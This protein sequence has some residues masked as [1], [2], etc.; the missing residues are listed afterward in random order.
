[1]KTVWS[2]VLTFGAMLIVLSGCGGGSTPPPPTTPPTITTTTVPGG[3]VNT[4]YSTTLSA[5]GGTAP[6]SWSVSSGTLPAGIKLSTSGTLSGTPTAAGKSSF[7]VQVTD[8]ANLSATQPLTLE[9][10]SGTLAFTNAAP[11]A[12]VV[13]TPYTFTFTA[14]G[15]IP[16]YKFSQSGSANSLPPGLSLS[17]AG[18]VS[19]TPTASGS[20][21]GPYEVEDSAENTFQTGFTFTINTSAVQLPQGGYAFGFGGKTAASGTP[22]NN[23]LALN[24]AYLMNAAQ[25]IGVGFY[26]E[27]TTA[28]APL[29]SQ[30]LAGGTVAIGANRLG[31]VAMTLADSSTVT[32][33]VAAPTGIGNANDTSTMRII[34]FDDTT[35]KGRRGAGVIKFQPTNSTVTTLT[36]GYVFSL[37]GLDASGNRVSL[38]GQFVA[39]GSGGVTS[40]VADKNDN[41]VVTHLTG[42]AGSYTLD[43]L[44]RA[45]VKLP[46]NGTTFTYA[47]YPVSQTEFTAITGDQTSATVPLLSGTVLAQ[48]GT[49]SNA[50]LQGVDVLEV[51][52]AAAGTA[53]LTVGLATVDGA[54]TITLKIDENNNGLLAPQT[55]SGTYLVDPTT[56]R[57]AITAT[58][59]PPILYLV[60]PNQALVVGTDAS[61]S[62]GVLEAQTG[63]SF[64]NGSFKGSYLGGNM[65]L[66]MDEVTNTV[67]LLDA[68]GNG[69]VTITSDSSGPGG[70]ATNQSG[71]G[72]Y[73]VDGTGRVLLTAGGN[74]EGIFYVVSPTKVVFLTANANGFIGSFEQ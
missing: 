44:G 57:V 36:G 1:M 8:S 51:V 5:T 21:A 64:T 2:C 65:P 6:L 22:A 26:D 17:A 34:E 54:G 58:G 7:T 29:A 35:G 4:A 32:F 49:F 19:G 13:N 42:S 37:S 30:T 52:G 14:S 61:A 47:L 63:S 46:L 11:P 3:T 24:G 23:G 38:A 10:S 71:T 15:G 48:S 59:T 40:V 33:A 50:S 45:A 74:T 55:V 62:G 18:V 28:S 68:D 53:D 72:A 31:T 69:S 56:G 70:L 12:G 39:D 9:I 16:P 73:A 25:S 66:P 67:A 41:G 43:A 20:F 60:G 27:N